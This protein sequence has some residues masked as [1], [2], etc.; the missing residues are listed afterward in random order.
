MSV[1]QELVWT[2]Y[3]TYSQC[4]Y[5]NQ[6]ITKQDMISSYDLDHTIIKPKHGS[7]FSNKKNNEWMF[8]PN[9]VN[10]IRE[11]VT[12]NN[13]KFVIVTN[14][15]NLNKK[16]NELEIWKTKVNEVVKIIDLPCIVLVSFR[17]DRYRKPSP[18][19]L[20]DNFEFNADGS[21]Y[22]GDAGGIYVDRTY[23]HNGNTIKYDK[24]FSDTDYKFALN[25]GIKFIHRDE[26]VNG[27][28]SRSL[29]ITY[30]KLDILAN[31]KELSTATFEPITTNKLE[32]ILLVGTPG[33]GK[34]SISRKYSKLGYVIINQD[35]LKTAKKC[36]TLSKI[37]I[38]NNQS[39]VIDNTNP[40]KL[41]RQ[42]Y[43]Q[44]IHDSNKTNDYNIKCIYFDVSQDIS[45]HNNIY[46]NIINPQREVVPRI[47]YDVFKKKFEMPNVDEGFDQI[48]ILKHALDNSL[49]K[50]SNVYF[51]YYF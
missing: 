20:K 31:E 7:L 47:A 6:T 44:L 15:K 2:N 38:E 33:C 18:F 11:S 1:N 8:L 13:S 28:T 49:I 39:L 51:N 3:P 48:I 12:S 37:A 25:L 23:V 17:D 40:S 19:I 22:C 30:P 10:K 45:K 46:R 42:S 29:T 35:T 34:S 16:M 4:S 21:F 41:V 9:I 24:D 26:Y 5:K 32:L 50:D 43:I 36:I 14:Q 27:D